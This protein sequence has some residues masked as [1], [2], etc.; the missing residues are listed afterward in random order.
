MHPNL[1]WVSAVTLASFLCKSH[2]CSDT[3]QASPPSKTLKTIQV[4]SSP[5]P[6]TLPVFPRTVQGH[7]LLQ[8]PGLRTERQELG[9]RPCASGTRQTFTEVLVILPGRSAPTAS[10]LAAWSSPSGGLGLEPN[11]G[12]FHAE[13]GFSS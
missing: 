13:Y 1:P 8:N 12:T 7:L 11:S 6:P 4:F 5:E 9:T 2:S 10:H 3:P